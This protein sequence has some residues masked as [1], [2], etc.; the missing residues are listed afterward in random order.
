VPFATYTQLKDSV[1]DWADGEDLASVIDDLVLI[2][3]A[4]LN[5]DVVSTRRSTL[6]TYGGVT[7]QTLALPSDLWEIEHFRIDAANQQALE[8]LP[9]KAFWD[10]A[11]AYESGVPA[12]YTV[13]G[14]SLF[15]APAPSSATSFALDYVATIPGLAANPAG[16]WLSVSHPDAYLYSVLAEAMLYVQDDAAAQR[17][18]ALR[19]KVITDIGGVSIR[20]ETRPLMRAIAG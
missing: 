19:E 6:A 2:A 15:V 5:R 7:V 14:A 8:F 17:W 3:E 13:Y 18:I 9:H 16:N 4:K 1:L 10:R 12:L 20:F 11:S